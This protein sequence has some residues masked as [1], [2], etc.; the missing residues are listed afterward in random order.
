MDI[1]FA[2]FVVL[3]EVD[4]LDDVLAA[5]VRAGASGATILDSQGMASLIVDRKNLHIPIFDTFKSM[6]EDSRPYNKTIFSVLE[7]QDLVDKTA[8][9]IQEVMEDVPGPGL[10]FMFTVPISNSY[11][12]GS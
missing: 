11:T 3:N 9:E 1:I 8:N 4:Y 12:L 5:F 6:I 7:N 10:G 2:L